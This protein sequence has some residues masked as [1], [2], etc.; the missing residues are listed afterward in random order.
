MRPRDSVA[1]GPFGPCDAPHRGPA[2]PACRQRTRRPAADSQRSG[3]LQWGHAI[4][5]GI[6]SSAAIRCDFAILSLILAHAAAI[7]PCRRCR[8]MTPARIR[9]RRPATGRPGNWPLVGERT[10][11]RRALAVAIGGAV[12][13]RALSL[14]ELRARPSRAGGRHPLRHALVEAGRS[15]SADPLAELLEL[16]EPGQRGRFCLVRRP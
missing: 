9:F 16:A 3:W 15:L 12:E 14:A 10:A 1:A 2:S 7:R 8:T 4:E 13:P 11:S 6:S 5:R